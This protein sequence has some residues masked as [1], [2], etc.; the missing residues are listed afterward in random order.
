LAFHLAGIQ[1]GAA[2]LFSVARNVAPPD[3]RWNGIYPIFG[4][5]LNAI[6]LLEEKRSCETVMDLN[7]HERSRT[8]HQ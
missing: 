2:R 1:Y 8:Q 7:E 3:C 6:E 5:A 4:F